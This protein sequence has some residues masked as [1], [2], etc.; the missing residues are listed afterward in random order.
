MVL[1]AYSV[2]GNFPNM[3]NQSKRQPLK[4]S[5][6]YTGSEKSEWI[7]GQQ[8]NQRIDGQGGHDAIAGRA[9]DDVILGGTGND[10]LAGDGGKNTL[11][12]GAGD[13]KFFF[14]YRNGVGDTLITD[15]SQGDK[16]VL[17]NGLYKNYRIRDKGARFELYE[18]GNL[19]ARVDNLIGKFNKNDVL[20]KKAEGIDFPSPGSDGM[21]AGSSG[22]L[23]AASRGLSDAARYF[24]YFWEGSNKSERHSA[25][26]GKTALLVGRGGDDTINGANKDD[27]LEG[28][29]GNDQVSGG[30]GKD[31]LQ[32]HKGSDRLEGGK[33]NDKLDGG[34]GNDTL[35]G[36]AGNDT[37][38]DDDGTNVFTGGKGKDFFEIED[39]DD[40]FV[41]IT[42]FNGK[43]DKLVIDDNYEFFDDF[44]RTVVN[45]NME[46]RLDGE[47]VAQL[48]GVTQLTNKMIDWD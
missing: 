40:G 31:N 43:Q 44:E 25:K 24:D 17:D 29:E 7:V 28:K 9:G 16:I 48:D 4:V 33:G 20:N 45:G 38:E 14:E 30:D 42:D 47:F 34:D 1:Y 35:I 12:G 41:T 18:K 21:P 32:G 6:N 36:G 10:H 19:V 27:K 3:S 11:V 13:D 15:F 23:N 5:G 39:D 8:S 46:I 26:D 2:S 37:F 22:D